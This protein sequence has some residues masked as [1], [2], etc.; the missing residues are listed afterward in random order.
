MNSKHVEIRQ[1]QNSGYYYYNLNVPSLILTI[2]VHIWA[3]VFKNDQGKISGRKPL[4][5]LKGHGLLKS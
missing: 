3:R 5:K 1:P 4:K 2:M